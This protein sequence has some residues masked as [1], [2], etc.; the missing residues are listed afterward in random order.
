MS[1]VF[2]AYMW[3]IFG[4]AMH[5]PVTCVCEC[6]R[7]HVC[8]CVCMCVFVCLVTHRSSVDSVYV[9]SYVCMKVNQVLRYALNICVDM[10]ALKNV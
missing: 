6:V 3:C 7:V 8:L 10:Y 5:V 1:C 9:N 2:G 4:V